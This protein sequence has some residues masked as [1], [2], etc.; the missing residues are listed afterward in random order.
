MR[1]ITRMCLSFAFLQG[2]LHEGT[3]Q[4]RKGRKVLIHLYKVTLKNG[5]TRTDP[6]VIQLLW[7]QTALVELPRGS[8]T[9]H[10]CRGKKHSSPSSTKH[11]SM[12]LF[13]KTFYNGS[14]STL[15]GY[16]CQLFWKLE[17]NVKYC[18]LKSKQKWQEATRVFLIHHIIL[19]TSL[20]CPQSFEFD[21]T[22]IPLP[23]SQ[24][25][26]HWVQSW[27]TSAFKMQF[28]SATGKS[29]LRLT[30]SEPLACW[31]T[32]FRTY[33]GNHIDLLSLQ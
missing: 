17:W 5:K 31:R 32:V 29:V 19:Y 24:K 23:L 6:E 28:S 9:A 22:T 1:F 4:R 16:L 25:P 12:S 26:H 14:S 8:S 21:T 2:M 15:F 11:S 20:T 33:N 27:K 7:V 3:A 30:S 13:C 18:S 10:Y